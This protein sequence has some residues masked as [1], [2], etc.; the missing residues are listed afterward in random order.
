MVRNARGEFGLAGI[1]TGDGEL[2]GQD[3]W[4]WCKKMGIRQVQVEM[5]EV[6][7]REV[8]QNLRVIW[9]WMKCDKKVNCMAQWL[10]E[11]CAGQNVVG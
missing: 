7:E 3:C 6:K 10:L 4:N 11:K 1:C 2:E 8:P 9:M 5:D